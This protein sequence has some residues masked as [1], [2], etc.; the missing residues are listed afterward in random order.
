MSEDVTGILTA[1][2]DELR[3]IRQA[4]GIEGRSMSREQAAEFL[5]VHKDTLYRLAREGEIAYFQT[6]D[7]GKMTF[8]L[9]DLLAYRSK[10]RHA[11]VE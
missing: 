10:T 3:L 5:G 8:T 1:V 9:D 4:Q 11:A 2:L 7:G 6:G